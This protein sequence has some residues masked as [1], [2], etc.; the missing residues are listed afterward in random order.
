MRAVPQSKL[1]REENIDKMMG[2]NRWARRKSIEVR[3]MYPFYVALLLV[4]TQ[5]A[6]AKPVPDQPDQLASQYSANTPVRRGKEL[7]EAAHAT[8][9][10]WA[11][12]HRSRA[13][14][15]A[16]EFIALFNELKQDTVMANSSRRELGGQ[17]RSRLAR[18]AEMISKNNA[19]NGR[20]VSPPTLGKAADGPAVLGQMGG[21]PNRRQG[22]GN[23]NHSGPRTAS[24]GSSG[25]GL[26]RDA[27]EELVELIRK[28]I[29]PS[30]WDV[31]GG[32]GTIHYWRPGRALVVRAS[33]DVHEQ[34][35][36]VLG[37]LH[38]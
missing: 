25:N 1:S 4:T 22:M 7:E 18:L 15:A 12:V 19:E 24:G 23:P 37:Q 11:G 34:I 17:V 6:E 8:L 32:L 9:R 26:P 3:I 33:D 30:S 5:P 20:D 31:N 28:T 2:R 36:G 10:R 27:G 13:E 16:R 35:G 29:A 38:Q 21:G 14:S